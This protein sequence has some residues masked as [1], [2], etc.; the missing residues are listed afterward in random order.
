MLSP[1]GARGRGLRRCNEHASHLVQHCFP[2]MVEL[3]NAQGVALALTTPSKARTGLHLAVMSGV[4]EVAKLLEVTYPNPD[5]QVGG[6]CVQRILL[7][8]LRRTYM[9]CLGCV[10]AGR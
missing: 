9:L 5:L 10:R 8:T 1:V 4:V 6:S 2:Q 3:L 7:F